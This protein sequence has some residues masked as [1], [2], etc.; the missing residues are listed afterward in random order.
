MSE[1]FSHRVETVSWPLQEPFIIANYRWETIEAVRV[2]IDVEDT[3]GRGEAVPLFYGSES[4]TEVA[5]AIRSWL[6]ERPTLPGREQVLSAELVGS[7][8][9]ALDAAL[10]DLEAKRSGRPVWQLLGQGKPTPLPAL[11]TLGL[12]SPQS[13]ARQAGELQGF[14]VLKLKLDAVGIVERVL[15]V[16]AE[17]PDATLVIDANG[18]WSMDELMGSMPVLVDAGVAMLEQPLPAG[19]DRD[20]ALNQWDSPIPLCADESCQSV[21][22]LETLSGRYSMI[23]IKLD[24]CGGLTAALD[25]AATARAMGFE[26]MVGNMLGSS[27]A[28]APAFYLAQQSRFADLDGPLFLSTDYDTPLVFSDGV[29]S[30]PQALLW[31]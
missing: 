11:V 1:D 25:L 16:R 30:I 23:N 8:R 2:T 15:A 12:G 29:V 20:A 28:M 18:S 17:R 9:N 13:M 26:I 24:K 31:G 22:D 19:R 3:A 21:A 27:L 14:P 6:A 5:V 4:P 7:A 10:W